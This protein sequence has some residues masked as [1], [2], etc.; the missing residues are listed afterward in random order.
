MAAEQLRQLDRADFPQL[1][2]WVCTS[3]AK[4]R[5][6]GGRRPWHPRPWELEVQSYLRT[7]KPKTPG[8]LWGAFHGPELR[9]VAHLD[10]SEDFGATIIRALARAEAYRGQHLGEVMLEQCIRFAAGAVQR[11]TADVLVAKIDHRNEPS[12]RLF[13]SK[14]FTR[15]GSDPHSG[16]ELWLR[17]V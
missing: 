3:P 11:A 5:Y 7:L 8:V 6:Q 4:A 17:N 2:Q 13:D 12:R 9:A 14:G 10:F 15:E 16:L 1:Q